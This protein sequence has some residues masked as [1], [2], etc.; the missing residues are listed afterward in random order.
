MYEPPPPGL[1]KIFHGLCLYSELTFLGLKFE[2]FDCVN[3]LIAAFISNM[4]IFHVF[5]LPKLTHDFINQ[6][7]CGLYFYLCTLQLVLVLKVRGTNLIKIVQ[8]TF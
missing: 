4:Q 7:Q 1:K 2:L 8:R 6:V 3:R 5:F